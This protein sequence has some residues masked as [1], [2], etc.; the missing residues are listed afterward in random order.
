LG[1]V[2]RGMME[3][4][5]NFLCGKIKLFH[6]SDLIGMNCINLNYCKLYFSGA[7]SRIAITANYLINHSL[8]IKVERVSSV[9]KSLPTG[10]AIEKHS[11][12]K[13]DT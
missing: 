9:K 2:A 13:I 1:V 5:S 12:S 3:H 7:T 10:Y 11:V 6:R 4:L 8:S